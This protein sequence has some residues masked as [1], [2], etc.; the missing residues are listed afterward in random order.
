MN[1]PPTQTNPA[2]DQSMA[3]WFSEEVQPHEPML[4]AWLQARFPSL[5]DT[6]DLVQESYVRLIRARERGQV[7]N[8]R[9]YLFKTAL[10]AALDLLRR[11]KVVP[12]E[13]VGESDSLFVLEESPHAGETASRTEE[14]E[15]LREAMHALPTRCR[16]VFTLRKLYGLSHREIA[17][18]LDI[19]EK[20]VEEQVN[21]AMRRCAAFLR[22]RGLP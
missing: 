14:L 6:D 9:N 17:A 8:A 5:T 20:T 12:F 10:N 4:R 18:Q 7:R 19:S 15:I 2:I 1:P 3:R 13:P 22:S 21:R 11:N 16:Q